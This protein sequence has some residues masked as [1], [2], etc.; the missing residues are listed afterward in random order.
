MEKKRNTVSLR[1]S[2][3][4]FGWSGYETTRVQGTS[5]GVTNLVLVLLTLL[6][7]NLVCCLCE[8][9]L[10]DGEFM[11]LLL[12]CNLLL[13]LFE[14]LLSLLQLDIQGVGAHLL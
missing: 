11:Q 14:F 12:V 13:V 3:G 9:Q 6:L 7:S 2:L 1:T 4:S 10:L 8:L 5:G